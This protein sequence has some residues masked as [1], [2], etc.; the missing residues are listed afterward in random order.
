MHLPC[1]MG[2]ADFITFID[3]YWRY[4][5]VYLIKE[6]SEALNVFKIFKAEVEK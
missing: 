6:K 5:Y 1:F 3:D 4:G 2:E